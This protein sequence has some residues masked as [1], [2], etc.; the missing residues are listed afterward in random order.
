MKD[1]GSLLGDPSF[2]GLVVPKKRLCPRSG[3]HEDFRK[4]RPLKEGQQ[5]A[6][7]AR[8]KDVES[9]EAGGLL[10]IGTTWRLPPPKWKFSVPGPNKTRVDVLGC[11]HRQ[12]GALKG[13]SCFTGC[14]SRPKSIETHKKRRILWGFVAGICW[15]M[16][17]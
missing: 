7:A 12:H 14:H 13:P 10:Q 1:S 2:P 16:G 6:R 9:M 8:S 17:T 5:Q 4:A 3:S 15:E 11:K